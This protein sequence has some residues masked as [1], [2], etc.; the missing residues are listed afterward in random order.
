MITRS[1]ICQGSSSLRKK[2]KHRLRD[3]LRTS[4]G[5]RPPH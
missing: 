4:L 5:S 2:G 1:S 3:L